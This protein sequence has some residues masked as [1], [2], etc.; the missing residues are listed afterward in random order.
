MQNAAILPERS[1]EA[2]EVEFTSAREAIRAFLCRT[3][4]K[5]AVSPSESSVLSNTVSPLLRGTVRSSPSN[6]I[7]PASSA[8]PSRAAPTGSKRQG[9]CMISAKKRQARRVAPPPTAIAAPTSGR[10]KSGSASPSKTTV[11]AREPPDRGHAQDALCASWHG[12]TARLPHQQLLAD[13]GGIP[14]K[15]HPYRAVAEVDGAV[16]IEQKQGYLPQ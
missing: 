11:T 8:T 10:A 12:K 15:T 2:G 5:A 3:A 16:E 13:R 7:S 9:M 1:P 14:R 6:T 4:G